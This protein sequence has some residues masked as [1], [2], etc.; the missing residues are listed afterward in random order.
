MRMFSSI[1][2]LIF[3]EFNM[4]ARVE[5][6]LGLD[7]GTRRAGVAF[8]DSERRIAMPIETYQ[9]QTPERDAEHF[10]ALVAEYAIDRLVVGL[11]VQAGGGEGASA[12]RARDWG[13]WLGQVTGLPVVF[14]DERYSSVEAEEILRGA[15]VKHSKRRN[16]RDRIAAREILQSYL[17]TP[18]SNAQDASDALERSLDD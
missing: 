10:R 7:Y 13:N 9:R 15:N 8:G 2:K 11:P 14:H 1:Q 4:T 3:D 18:K 12:K 16:Q 5:N 6:L 17:D